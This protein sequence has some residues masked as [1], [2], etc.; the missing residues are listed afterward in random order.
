MKPSKHSHAFAEIH[1]LPSP[2]PNTFSE[3]QLAD[4]EKY[5]K[6]KD[7]E[8]QRLHYEK[9]KEN[10]TAPR[11]KPV[12]DMTEAEL[13]HTRQQTAKGC[14]KAYAMKQAL[15]EV[16]IRHGLPVPSHMNDTSIK[17]LRLLLRQKLSNDEIQAIEDKAVAQHLE[18]GPHKRK[19]AEEHGTRK[20][21]PVPAV[22]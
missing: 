8:R 9:R 20:P 14:A 13:E 6:E 7:Q 15:R 19:A 4:F 3:T 5:K 21:G 12:S 11:Y 10:G 22:E 18:K 16:A 2:N 17:G 1:G